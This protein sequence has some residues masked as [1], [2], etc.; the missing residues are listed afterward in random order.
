MVPYFIDKRTEAWGRSRDLPN[1]TKLVQSSAKP[2][3]KPLIS[4]ICRELLPSPRCFPR[5]IELTVKK[6]EVLSVQFKSFQ[7]R[8]DCP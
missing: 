8:N 3:M 1:V 5:S 7:Y 2:G 6:G 4:E